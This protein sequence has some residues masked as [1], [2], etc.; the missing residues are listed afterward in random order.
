MLVRYYTLECDGCGCADYWKSN[1]QEAIE[2]F[3]SIGYII[4]SNG[5]TYCNKEC[6]EKDK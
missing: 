6:E 3:K 5:K 2:Y 1:K 4:K